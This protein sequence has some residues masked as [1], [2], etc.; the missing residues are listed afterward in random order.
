MQIKRISTTTKPIMQLD[1]E[2]HNKQHYCTAVDCNA[3]FESKN[4][5]SAH[6]RLFLHARNAHGTMIT[7]SCFETCP[8]KQQD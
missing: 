1:F 5:T 6:A 4:T 7:Y 8:Y 2:L 3:T